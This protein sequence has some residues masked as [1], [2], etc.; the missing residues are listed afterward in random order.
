MF[1]SFG[2]I[3]RRSLLTEHRRQYLHLPYGGA[4]VTSR[5][6]GQ[7]VLVPLRQCGSRNITVSLCKTAQAVPHVEN[8]VLIGQGV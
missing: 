3:P 8:M 4:V 5:H 2:P 1:P 7:S 6:R